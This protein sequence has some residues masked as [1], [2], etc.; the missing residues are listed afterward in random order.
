MAGALFGLKIGLLT[1]LR[2]ERRNA[3][4]AARQGLG[5]RSR[6]AYRPFVAQNAAFCSRVPIALQA[7]GVLDS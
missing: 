1:V 3:I 6:L 5:I 7:D 2:G 4:A